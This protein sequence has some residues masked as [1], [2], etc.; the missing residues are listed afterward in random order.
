[1]ATAGRAVAAIVLG[2]GL[3]DWVSVIYEKHPTIMMIDFFPQQLKGRLPPFRR[4]SKS[5]SNHFLETIS[6]SDEFSPSELKSY[7]ANEISDLARPVNSTHCQLRRFRCYRSEPNLCRMASHC[8]T[9][10]SQHDI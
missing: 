1:M 6:L 5:Q 4:H 2:I 10:E 3:N 8:A 9:A 7:P